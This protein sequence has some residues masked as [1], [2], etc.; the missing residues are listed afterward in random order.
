MSQ[1]LPTKQTLGLQV[2]EAADTRHD[3]TREDGD[4]EADIG[5]EDGEETSV[6]TN[7]SLK[8]SWSDLTAHLPKLRV[9]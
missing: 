1:L 4:G 7:T 9:I 3:E 5:K 6:N 2:V 8:T